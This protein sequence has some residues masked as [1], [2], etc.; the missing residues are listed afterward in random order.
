[1]T[2]EETIARTAQV[3][4]ACGGDAEGIAWCWRKLQE[5]VQRQLDGRGDE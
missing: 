4:I 2:D 3:W 1:M 5:E